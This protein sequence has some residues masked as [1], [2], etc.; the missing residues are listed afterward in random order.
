MC[1]RPTTPA[2]APLVVVR[3]KRG[4]PGRIPKLVVPPAPLFSSTSPTTALISPPSQSPAQGEAP[5]AATSVLVALPV[6]LPSFAAQ[7]AAHWTA[8]PSSA[9]PTA[10]S[11]LFTAP[12]AA[13]TSAAAPSLTS[14]QAALPSFLVAPPA[15]A[16]PS[17]SALRSAPQS[18]L[19][20]Q[21][22]AQSA[23]PLEPIF[24]ASL[25]SAGFDASYAPSAVALPVGLH[26]LSAT[27]R[28]APSAGPQAELHSSA[29]PRTTST[30][31]RWRWLLPWDQQL[32]CA[33]IAARF[34]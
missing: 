34:N 24:S 1:L 3:P 17:S 25:L 19:A 16:P 7:G 18:L 23:S 12:P 22:A 26:S 27:Q 31:L 9:A 10:E 29:A 2:A 14:L 15:A 33:L 8:P 6:A 4:A 11:S 5:T 28:A 30:G 32:L 20:A 21:Q 13:F